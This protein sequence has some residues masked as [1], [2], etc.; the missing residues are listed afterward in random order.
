MITIEKKSVRNRR[1]NF[2]ASLEG[3]LLPEGQALKKIEAAFAAIVSVET[4]RE[5]FENM[6][7]EEFNA[8]ST[9]V[10]I[11]GQLIRLDYRFLYQGND[12]ILVGSLVPEAFVINRKPC[13]TCQHCKPSLYA[14]N[15]MTQKTHEALERIFSSFSH[16]N[17][18]DTT[19]ISF[20]L[21]NA[22][23]TS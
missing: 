6:T 23:C 5:R 21:G 11:D 19:S 3:V 7:P 22:T 18:K 20:S 9:H 17:G 13:E 15:H 4:A 12:T 16:W 2:E 8:S 10:G 14:A 1:E